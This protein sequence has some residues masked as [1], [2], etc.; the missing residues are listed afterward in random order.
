MGYK[1]GSD[2]SV[3]R[4][5]RRCAH[6]QLDRAVAELSERANE[7]P[8][9]AVHSARKSIKKQRS[10]L[11]LARGAMPRE[12]RGRENAALRK[13]AR[14]LSG[15]R[16]ADVMIASISDLSER[17]AGQLPATAFGT[18]RA[19]FEASRNGDARSSII[20]RHAVRQ[21]RHAT[22]R[23][24]RWDLRKGGWEALESGL[25]RSYKRGRRAFARTHSNG[26]MEE[27]HAW[28]KRAK[29][30]WYQER[31]LAPTCGPTV[32]GHVKEL[33]RLCDLLGDDHD[34]AVLRQ[35]LTKEGTEIAADLDAVVKLIDHR[36]DELQT[37]AS[38]LGERLYAEK[39]KAFR[40][41]MRASWQAGRALSRAPEQQRPADLAAATR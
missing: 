18:I 32:R 13:V 11:R 27:L 21:L 24:D 12:Q 17:Y 15:V 23:V 22:E 7:D 38:K 39:P 9:R 36:R 4:A 35:Q 40:R 10:L 41:R 26:S 37:E 2:E 34:L 31:L 14:G 28:R 16:D 20:D 6:E 30:L 33:D 19:H 29:D 3:R 1:F 8:V 25:L 5:V